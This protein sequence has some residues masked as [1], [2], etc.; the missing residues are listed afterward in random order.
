MGDRPLSIRQS[1]GP[2]Y[3]RL[4]ELARFKSVLMGP[5]LGYEI[6]VSA[7][8]AD[9]FSGGTSN[10]KGTVDTT[11]PDDYDV[12]QETASQC[13]RRHATETYS[14]IGVRYPS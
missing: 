5:G 14:Q 6:Q 1:K 7:V 11:Q 10:K 3:A 2:Q 13:E 8:V 12:E 4:E 9:C